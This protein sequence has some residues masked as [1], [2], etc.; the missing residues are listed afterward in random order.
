MVLIKYVFDSFDLGSSQ[1]MHSFKRCVPTVYGLFLF[2][3]IVG[4]SMQ[5]QVCEMSQC[6]EVFS[7]AWGWEDGWSSVQQ[8][9]QQ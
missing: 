9:G 2:V 3:Y 7:W 4:K 8:G 6:R 5:F 1:L